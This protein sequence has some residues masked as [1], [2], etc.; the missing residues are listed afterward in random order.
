MGFYATLR[1]RDDKYLFAG[2]IVIS[3][4][5]DYRCDYLTPLEVLVLVIRVKLVAIFF[6]LR[7]MLF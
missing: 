7:E 1:F 2:N 3:M 6:A 5:I 4:R